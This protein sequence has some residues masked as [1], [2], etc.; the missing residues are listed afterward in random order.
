MKKLAITGYPSNPPYNLFEQLHSLEELYLYG[1]E[2]G[3]FTDIEYILH[4][5]SL[6]VLSLIFNYRIKDYERIGELTNLS[7]LN[8]QYYTEGDDTSWTHTL[9]KLKH[10]ALY[11]IKKI[12]DVSTL[13]KLPNLET[14]ILYRSTVNNIES[15]LESGSIRRIGN[16][17]NRI[18]D[19]KLFYDKGIIVFD[20][21]DR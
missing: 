14:V 20:E 2:N 3:G 10:I 5:Q 13:S 1:W 4:L 16:P 19:W 21:G 7:E 18:E 9:L 17:R 8:L 6:R 11:S 12:E 15:L